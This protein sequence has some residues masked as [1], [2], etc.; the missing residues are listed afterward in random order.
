M[1]NLVNQ[2]VSSTGD[3]TSQRI[4]KAESSIAQQVWVAM[5]VLLFLF[6]MTSTVAHLLIK[7]IDS[8][9]TQLV[10]AV[11]LVVEGGGETE[12][13]ALARSLAEWGT[14][15]T[16]ELAVWFLL[17]MTMFGVIIGITAAM[18]L[19]R[20]LI[21][22]NVILAL[23]KRSA[24]LQGGHV[25]FIRTISDA[26]VLSAYHGPAMSR[27]LETVDLGELAQVDM[28][29]RI[30]RILAG[31]EVRYPDRNPAPSPSLIRS[32]LHR[33][34]VFVAALEEAGIPVQG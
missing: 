6:F 23:W 3:K 31:R 13:V 15:D 22:P 30:G 1:D 18:V 4:R 7:Q 2:E 28:R 5:G 10:R 8:E 29:D 34:E 14:T 32:G 9:I 26:L 20:G 21:Q 17:S 16:I 12:T 25:G 19:S 11:E 27:L 24:M 33:P